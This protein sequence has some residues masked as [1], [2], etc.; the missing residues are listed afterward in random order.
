[1][2]SGHKFTKPIRRAR[3]CFYS[4]LID[5]YDDKVL[6]EDVDALGPPLDSVIALLRRRQVGVVLHGVQPSWVRLGPR[7]QPVV[8]E[9]RE[10]VRA[11]A[12]T[13]K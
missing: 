12:I 4:L 3:V 7:R 9:R 8:E 10:Y 13:L 11:V 2:T 1:M 5:G 6:F